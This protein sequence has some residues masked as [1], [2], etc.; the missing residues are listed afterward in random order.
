MYPD[1][2][3][4]NTDHSQQMSLTH[5][6]EY[7]KTCAAIVWHVI[8]RSVY[9]HRTPDCH[10]DGIGEPTAPISGTAYSLRLSLT[11]SRGRAPNGKLSS[12]VLSPATRICERTGHSPVDE[13][14][15]HRPLDSFPA[16]FKSQ[17]DS[18]NDTL[19][20]AIAG[21]AVRCGGRSYSPGRR[22]ASSIV[23]RVDGPTRK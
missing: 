4:A 11:L 14:R 19:G 3:H 6:S 21:P 20:L 13:R 9:F 18:L 17:R 10:I 15:H 16:R 22:T 7:K 8:P 5:A 12:S 1:V 2:Q 23:N